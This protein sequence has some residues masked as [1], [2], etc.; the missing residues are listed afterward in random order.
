VNTKTPH[1]GH[2]ISEAKI[3]YSKTD[4]SEMH[5]ELVH[6]NMR[7]HVTDTFVCSDMVLHCIKK[8]RRIHMER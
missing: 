7:E 2:W 3:I 5:T 1:I 6:V 4:K 8:Q